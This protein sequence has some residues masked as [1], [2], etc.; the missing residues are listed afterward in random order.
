MAFSFLFL[1][2]T[3]LLSLDKVSPVIPPNN[4]YF[5]IHRKRLTFNIQSYDILRLPVSNSIIRLKDI[6]PEEQCYDENN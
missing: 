5:F 4:A 1:E 6:T 3:A 2:I